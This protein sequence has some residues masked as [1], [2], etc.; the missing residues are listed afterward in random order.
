MVGVRRDAPPPKP[1]TAATAQARVVPSAVSA[2]PTVG[3]Y[4]PPQP[5]STPRPVRTSRSTPSP[6]ATVAPR[7][8]PTAS[9]TQ[10]ERRRERERPQLCSPRWL[11]NPFLREWCQRNGYR[12]R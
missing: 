11:E 3:E 4:V 12:A 8:R 1:Q 9:P 7:P 5:T 6:K 2:G 10:Q